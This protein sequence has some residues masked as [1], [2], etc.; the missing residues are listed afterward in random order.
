MLDKVQPCL[1]LKVH[2]QKDRGASFDLDI[3]VVE[4]SYG[5]GNWYEG[6]KGNGEIFMQKNKALNVHQRT[7]AII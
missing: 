5:T 4:S 6:I 3:A 7:N 1:P 2:S